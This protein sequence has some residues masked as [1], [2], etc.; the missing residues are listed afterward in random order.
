MKVI[1]YFISQRKLDY[2]KAQDSCSSW[3]KDKSKAISRVLV[4]NSMKKVM[5]CVCPATYQVSSDE[6]MLNSS[7]QNLNFS[8]NLAARSTSNFQYLCGT[9]IDALYT[10]SMSIGIFQTQPSELL[11]KV[12]VPFRLIQSG[13]NIQQATR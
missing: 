9:G 13:T 5:C 4:M 6:T 3:W 7:V 1:N 10:R 8:S 12:C 2:R 11:L